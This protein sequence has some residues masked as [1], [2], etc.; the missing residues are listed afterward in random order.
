[1]GPYGS[2]RFVL[3]VLVSLIHTSGCRSREQK[4]GCKGLFRENNICSGEFLLRGI[5]K[6]DQRTG[7]Q[8]FTFF[9]KFSIILIT[10]IIIKTSKEFTFENRTQ[11]FYLSTLYPSFGLRMSYFTQGRHR[12]SSYLKSPLLPTSRSTSG[13]SFT[14]WY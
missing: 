12:I 14:S 10:F 11:T 8:F 6:V 9:F 7:Q 3:E 4:S 2:L 5:F 1:M 13:K